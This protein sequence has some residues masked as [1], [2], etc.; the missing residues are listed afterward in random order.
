MN[1][2]TRPAS[3]FRPLLAACALGLLPSL[4]LAQQASHPVESAARAFLERETAGL[5]GKVAIEL[6]PLDARNQL[7]ACASMEA[8]L[9]AGTRAWGTV[10]VG[11]RCD[12][13]ITWTIYLQAKVSVMADY[14]VTARPIRAGQVLGPA[15]LSFRHGDLA[16]LP[17]NTLT[18]LTQAGGH[19][20]RYALAQ[21]TPLRGDMLRIPAAVRQGQNV[22]VVTRGEGFQ[23]AGEGRSLNN[24]APGET[25]RV[26]MANGQVVTGIATTDGS[27]EIR[28]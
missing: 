18:D 5:P 27:V 4:C 28:F 17:D 26:R 16:T 10:S 1:A 22:R 8:F 21:G 6:A 19:H 23:V 20:T 24:A 12:S 3:R 9:P 11:V 15:D 2:S 7:P 13:P 14:L 25:V